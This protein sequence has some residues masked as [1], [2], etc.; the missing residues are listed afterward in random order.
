MCRNFLDQRKHRGGLELLV[1]VGVNVSI[2]PRWRDI[3]LCESQHGGFVS[4]SNGIGQVQFIRRV[5]IHL[6]CPFVFGLMVLGF[7]A[8]DTG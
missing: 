3:L 4:R 7:M 1:G 2:S 5:Y 6:P 8:N